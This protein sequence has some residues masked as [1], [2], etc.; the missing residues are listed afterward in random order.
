[1]TLTL[2]PK[3]IRKLENE[4]EQKRAQKG[5]VFR[6]LATTSGGFG[7]RVDQPLSDDVVLEHDGTPLL[8]VAPGLAAHLSDTAL[9]VGQGADEPDW[10]LVRGG[11]AS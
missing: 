7:M 11:A 2:T 6:L 8:A 1:M 5:D 4:L 3:A 10:V 9:D